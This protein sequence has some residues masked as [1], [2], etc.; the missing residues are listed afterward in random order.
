MS[1]LFG[2]LQQDLDL[3]REDLQKLDSII[4]SVIK[5]TLLI[6][7]NVSPENDSENKMLHAISQQQIKTWQKLKFKKLYILDKLEKKYN[8]D[9]LIP[10]YQTYKLLNKHYNI[11]S[12]KKSK[13]LNF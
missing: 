3:L 7:F 9:K 2:K 1:S 11:L 4:S 13:G 10:S 6:R 8:T 12:E 5:N